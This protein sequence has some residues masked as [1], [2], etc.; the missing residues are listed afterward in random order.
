MKEITSKLGGDKLLWTILGLLS[1]FSILAVLSSTGTLAHKSGSY[2]F[3]FFI[4]HVGVLGLGWF[5]MYLTHLVDYRYYSRI[6]QILFFISIPLLVYTLMKGTD[7]NEAKRWITVP[8]IKLTF[9][10]SDL[11][12]LGLIMLLARTLSKKQTQIKSFKDAFIPLLAP[13]LVIVALI[14]PENLSTALVLFTTCVI[15][16]FIGRVSFWHIGTLALVSL[17]AF[18]F[19][20]MVLFIMPEDMMVKRMSTWKSRIESFTQ[21]GEKEVPYQ[22]KQ[23]NIAVAK[24]GLVRLAPGD[25]VQRNYL[26][27]PYS[28][29]IYAIIIEEY[30]LLGGAII[31]MLYLL[32]LYRCIRIVMKSP[33]AFG[34]F[35]SAGLGISLTIQ[36]LINMGVAVGLLPVTGMTLPLISMGG[37]S[38]WFTSI[39]LGIILSVSR[40][41]ESLN[42]NQI[43][44]QEEQAVPLEINIA[45]NG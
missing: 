42:E 26:P 2:T 39:S 17:L 40:S 16:L 31:M 8:I 9:Q 19:F 41:V 37:S 43:I 36:A 44:K 38:I 18:G 27:H 6:A 5:I 7:L 3:K 29:F 32:F 15:L 34:A 10:T 1:I 12:K 23:A 13:I 33:K 4:K 30:G 35:L 14:V 21:K 45:P 20:V 24:G 22:V 28:D 11:A 25:S